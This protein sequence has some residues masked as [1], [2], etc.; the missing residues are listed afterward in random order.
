[1]TGETVY[2]GVCGALLH[3]AFIVLRRYF[4]VRSVSGCLDPQIERKYEVA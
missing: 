2:W 1:M 4:R 3:K